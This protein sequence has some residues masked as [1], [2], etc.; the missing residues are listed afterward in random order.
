MAVVTYKFPVS[1]ST[2]P[3]IALM[4]SPKRSLVLVD[5]ACSDLSSFDVVHNFGL[6]AADIANGFPIC[7]KEY[8]VS[9]AGQSIRWNMAQD[10]DGNTLHFTNVLAA[11]GWTVR[12]V[13]QR[14]HSIIE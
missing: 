4:Q 11:V 3:S 5:V 2:P 6:S 12:F 14:P 1:G 10:A 7:F 9:V 13:I 8:I